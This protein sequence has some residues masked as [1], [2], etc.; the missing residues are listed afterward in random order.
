M[1]ILKDSDMRV[2]LLIQKAA[3]IKAALLNANHVEE[4]EVFERQFDINALMPHITGAV[5]E[6]LKKSLEIWYQD[7]VS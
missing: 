4:L 1:K 7:Y 2:R 3:I 5:A 6:T